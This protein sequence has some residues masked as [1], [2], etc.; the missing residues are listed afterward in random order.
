LVSARELTRHAASLEEQLARLDQLS[1]TWQATLQSTNQP[2]TPPLVLQSAQSVVNSIERT[3]Q[4]A[5]SG[6]DRVLTLQ[7]RLSEEEARHST[8]LELVF[9]F[10]FSLVD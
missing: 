8:D 10:L 5:E 6:R 9:E 2:E 1:K 4:A 7:S 3:R